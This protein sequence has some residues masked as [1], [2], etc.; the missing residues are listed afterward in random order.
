MV[1]QAGGEG[2]ST[3]HQQKAGEQKIKGDG[4]KKSIDNQ[5]KPNEIKR[6]SDGKQFQLKK[7]AAGRQ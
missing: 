6:K 5:P 2:Q 1:H 4:V 3:Q 7:K